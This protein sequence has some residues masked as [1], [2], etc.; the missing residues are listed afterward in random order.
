[1]D[2]YRALEEAGSTHMPHTAAT[3]VSVSSYCVTEGCISI[4]FQFHSED[5]LVQDGA[6]DVTQ[7]DGA[8]PSTQ[9]QFEA[10]MD[11]QVD[12]VLES[13]SDLEDVPSTQPMDC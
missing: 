1:L 11:T 13:Q 5:G 4:R 2:L 10:A 7:A 3:K 12:T 8:G 6:L 9:T